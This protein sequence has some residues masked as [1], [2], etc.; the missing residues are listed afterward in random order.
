M[1]RRQT[2]SLLLLIS[3]GHLLLVSA[4]VQST[5]GLPVIEAVAFDAFARVQGLLGGV[6]DGVRS[7]WSGYF[8]LKGVARENEA[9]K[10]RVLDLEMQVQEQQAAAGRVRG[11]QE[12]LSLKQSLSTP[13]LAARVIAGNPSPGSLTVTIDRGLDD[14][15]EPDMAVLAAR[16]VVGRVIPPVTAHAATVQLLI[17]RNAAAAITFEHS[18]AG[19]MVLG[20]AVDPPLRADFVPVLAD[21]QVGERVTTSGQDGIF[22]QGFLVGTVAEV[23]RTTPTDREIGIQPSVDFSHLDVVLVVLSKSAVV[24]AGTP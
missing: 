14:G 13:T 23:T 15:V 4:Q 3:L 7:T 19:G 16:G 17:G 10:S 8:A 18:G 1:L 6:G 2:F 22:P 5:S 11:L 20:G 24:P 21:V 12:A 9:L